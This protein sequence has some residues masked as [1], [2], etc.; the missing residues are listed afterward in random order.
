[1]V[2]FPASVQ[3]QLCINVE[4][5]ITIL[6]NYIRGFIRDNRFENSGNYFKSKKNL[7]ITIFLPLNEREI[8]HKNILNCNF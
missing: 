1:M 7:P 6:K 3:L 5:S 2:L 8:F 4:N